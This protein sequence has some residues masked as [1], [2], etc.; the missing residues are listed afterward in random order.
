M[1]RHTHAFQDIGRLSGHDVS[2]NAAAYSGKN[3]QK[4]RQ[5][6]IIAIACHHGSVD[7][8]DRKGSQPDG[9][10]IFMIRS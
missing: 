1:H 3:S 2:E 7:A 6:T 9:V 10:K 8:C 5:E 4:D